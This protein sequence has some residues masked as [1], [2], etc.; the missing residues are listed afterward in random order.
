MDSNFKN[1]EFSDR[2]VQS[3]VSFP[4]NSMRFNDLIGYGFPSLNLLVHGGK[5][6]GRDLFIMSILEKAI[7][8]GN[9]VFDVGSHS[10][11]DTIKDRFASRKEYALQQYDSLNEEYNHNHT[12]EFMK[13][14]K[15]ILEKSAPYSAALEEFDKCCSSV[16]NKAIYLVII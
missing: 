3:R 5:D 14:A 2:H 12:K 1:F 4:T 13:K 11:L 7:L 16:I 8:D 15:G 6:F 9:R 10:L